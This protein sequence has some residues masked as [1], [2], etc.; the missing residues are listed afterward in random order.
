MRVIAGE[1]KGRL[2]K[3]PQ[4]SKTRPATELVRGAIFSIIDSL[5]WDKGRVLDLFSGS[6]SLGI[7]ALSRGASWVD[8]VENDP[9]CCAI[10]NEN[11]RST[12]FEKQSHVYC[13]DVL[14][15]VS[16]LSEVYSLVLM[17]PP[18]SSPYIDR[19]LEA[20]SSSALLGRDTI[21]VVTHSARRPLK[22]GYGQL[23]LLRDYRHGD[24]VIN[25]YREAGVK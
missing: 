24:S 22:S 25:L 18:Y 12:G 4:N 8:F 20:L 13:L 5:G 10:I 23:V 19:T 6:G 3:V 1:A 11:L 16:S 15:A 17:D 2:L 21:V 14:R 7:E 9:R